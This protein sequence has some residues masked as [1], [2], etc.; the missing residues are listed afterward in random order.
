LPR[1]LYLLFRQMK[2]HDVGLDSQLVIEAIGRRVTH[3]AR[4]C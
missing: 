3:T 4:F 1:K 2:F